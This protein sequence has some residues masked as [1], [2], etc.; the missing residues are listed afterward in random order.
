MEPKLIL[1]YQAKNN[2]LYFSKIVF[3]RN[4]KIKIGTSSNV[5]DLYIQMTK[6]N[7]LLIL[8]SEEFHGMDHMVN[9]DG[10]YIYI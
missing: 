8:I 5:I 6:E 2:H 9:S 7:N 3:F 4:L 10:Q 1:Y